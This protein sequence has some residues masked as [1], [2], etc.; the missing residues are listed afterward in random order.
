MKV[1]SN[2]NY[3]QNLIIKKHS[4]LNEFN[5]LLLITKSVVFDWSIQLNIDSDW[6]PITY[7]TLTYAR[8]SIMYKEITSCYIL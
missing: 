1:G 4:N 5:P 7:N 6:L 3:Y 2:I 8:N